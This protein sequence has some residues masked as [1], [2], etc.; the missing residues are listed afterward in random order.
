MPR[1]AVLALGALFALLVPASA[2][3]APG[4]T[5]GAE[6][7]RAGESHVRPHGPADAVRVI[8]QP[9]DDGLAD[10]AMEQ[11]GARRVR[12]LEHVGAILADVPCTALAALQTAL[13]R[14]A[15]TLD[16]PIHATLDRTTDA[17]GARWVH[18]QLGFDGAGVAV[19]IIDSGIAP[20]QP[21]LDDR[22]V[23]FADFVDFQ[24]QPYDGYGHGTH[25]AGIIAASGA[26]G[27]SVR[28]IAPGADLVVLKTL[29]HEG[30]GYISDAIA[31]I[32]YAIAQRLGYNIRVINLSMATGV[33]ESYRTDPLALAAARAVDAGIVVVTA[34]GNLGRDAAGTVQH[35]GVTA[36]G[37]APWVLTVGAVTQTAAPAGAAESVAPFSSLGPSAIDLVEK[38]DVVAPG[39][40]IVSLAD[41]HGT[42][43]LRRPGSRRWGLTAD[44][45]EAYLS[46]SGTSMAASVAAGAV[47]VM[48]QAN[49]E[50]SPAAVKAI[51]QATAD[52]LEGYS[53]LAQGAGRLN[54]RAA[55]IVAASTDVAVLPSQAGQDGIWR[56]SAPR[57][58]P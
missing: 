16:R 37:N 22:V 24:P 35:G 55:V 49:P 1:L 47:A 34:A 27:G 43:Y 9:S 54:L 18:D 51:L 10:A 29:D 13:P 17:V 41:P 23:H 42:L 50:L 45:Q 48:L 40:D 19:A 11:A 31:A 52:P 2:G 12:R 30:R 7:A 5:C 53:R 8:L 39:T 56:A 21:A 3:V 44:P 20:S 4:P 46:L 36:P 38:P 58:A 32:D 26:G 28:G 6:I 15:V 57:V 14:G 25:V 33:Y